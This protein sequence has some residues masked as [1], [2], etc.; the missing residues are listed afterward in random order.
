MSRTEAAA[1]ITPATRATQCSIDGCDVADLLARVDPDDVDAEAR[2]LCPTHRVE[3][4]R[5]V[6]ER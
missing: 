2:V 5:E 1:T 6:S 4:L 3:Y